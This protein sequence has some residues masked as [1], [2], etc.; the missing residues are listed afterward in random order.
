MPYNAPGLSD[1][2]AR[3]EQNI[4]QRL[5]GSW[6][7]AR[8]KTLSALGYAQAGLAAGCHEHIEWVSRQIIPGSAD[9]VELLK[10]CQFWGV[11]RKQASRA[12]EDITVTVTAATT[13]PARTR[14]QRADGQVFVSTAAVSSGAAGKIAVNVTAV[15]AGTVGNT[16]AGTMLSLI[17][18]MADILPDATADKG[19]TGGA[20]TESA[21]ELLA[22]LEF[23]VQ[24]PPFGGNKFDYVRWA[25]EVPGVTR[26]WCLPTW[27]QAGSVGVTF[28]QD[29]N[30]DIFPTESDVARVDSYIS[31]HPDPVT[32]LIIGKPDGVIVKT[33]ALTPR[34]VNM[35]IY[36]S[37]NT[38]AMQQAVKKAMTALFYN[39]ASPGGSMPPSHITRAVAGVTGLTDFA[40]R[41]PVDI[42][43]SGAT[44]LLVP[45]VI[46][47][48]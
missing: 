45:G 41:A 38:D 29:N 48:K 4:E 32:G 28:V 44:E 46:T 27:P 24:Y 18:P 26:A 39:E 35:D 7:Q 47:W 42:Q 10:H 9:E 30:D 3:T 40:V 37:P 36:I 25:R 6:P 5:P 34:P 33:F 23:R 15:N 22:R 16:P 20:D 21:G 11:R 43:Y 17:T 19:I 31:G 2:I 8:E 1:L 14:W 12:S 13:V